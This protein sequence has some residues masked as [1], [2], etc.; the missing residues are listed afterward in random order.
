MYREILI[1]VKH[2]EIHKNKIKVITL[3]FENFHLFVE[4]DT[5]LKKKLTGISK[6]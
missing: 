1:Y 3:C 4:R 6:D 2:L 5:I